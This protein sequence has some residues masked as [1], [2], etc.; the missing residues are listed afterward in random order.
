MLSKLLQQSLQFTGMGGPMGVYENYDTNRCQDG[1]TFCVQMDNEGFY[2]NPV[3]E[4]V[5]L[6]GG[7]NPFC[8]KALDCNGLPT[9]LRGTDW[10]GPGDG[11]F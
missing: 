2:G 4:A 6:A 5:A 9:H 7:K 10:G 8:P 3:D 11:I 1:G